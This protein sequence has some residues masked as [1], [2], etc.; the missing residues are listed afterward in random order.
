[1]KGSK[2]PMKMTNQSLISFSHLVDLHYNEDAVK[3][4][5]PLGMYLQTYHDF[6]IEKQA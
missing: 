1:M 2:N 4:K 3:E 5:F 6:R